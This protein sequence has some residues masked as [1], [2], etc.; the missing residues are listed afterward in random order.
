MHIKFEME[1]K[2]FLTKLQPFQ[3]QDL[4]RLWLIQD[5]LEDWAIDKVRRRM[6]GWAEGQAQH[7]GI[8][9]VLRTQFSVLFSV[10]FLNQSRRPVLQTS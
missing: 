6:M 10:P 7:G 3:T 2:L 1:K 9:C 5:F 4:F 8:I